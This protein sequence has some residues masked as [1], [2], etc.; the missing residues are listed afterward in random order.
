MGGGL[1][2]R[3]E[4]PVTAAVDAIAAWRSAPRNSGRLR[5]A[6]GDRFFSLAI[7][8]ARSASAARLSKVSPT[9]V[10][11]LAFRLQPARRNRRTKEIP[12][13]SVAA[14]A[15]IIDA[16]GVCHI[17]SGSWRRSASKLFCVSASAR[18]QRLARAARRPSDA[19]STAAPRTARS[20]PR[21]WDRASGYRP[22]AWR[23][24]SPQ[25]A[26]S[27]WPKASSLALAGSPGSDR[28][29]PRARNVMSAGL[30]RPRP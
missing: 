20:R 13:R 6:A 27:S 10:T 30:D 7:A 8:C 16:H 15:S 26:A 17:S 5:P 12:P 3:A 19:P 9:T 23:R 21:R 24:R 14:T 11:A 2:V 1:R 18:A 4:Q 25:R 22:A 28:D 29:I